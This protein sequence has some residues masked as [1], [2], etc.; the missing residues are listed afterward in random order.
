MTRDDAIAYND[1]FKT[2]L[3]KISK[4]KEQEP[5]DAISREAVLSVIDG[6]YEQ[7]RDTENIED[8][9]ILITYMSSVQPI[10]KGHWVHKGQGIY[11][12]ECGKESGYNPFGASRFSDYCPN[13]GA[14]MVESQESEDKKC[15]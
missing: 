7:N 5:C 14:E 8:L 2:A 12:S 11:C 3:E 9:I 6:W 15:R 10:R 1:D 13:C 4:Y